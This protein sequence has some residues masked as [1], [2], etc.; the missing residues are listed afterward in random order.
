MR[1][2]PL[3]PGQKPTTTTGTQAARF[4]KV[5]GLGSE[6]LERVNS[7]RVSRSVSTQCQG[8]IASRKCVIANG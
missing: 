2:K 7:T 6:R 1:R 3:V 4:R 8:A 5:F